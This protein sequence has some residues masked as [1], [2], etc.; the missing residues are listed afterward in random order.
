MGETD[1]VYACTLTRE[2]ADG[3]IDADRALADRV[4]GSERTQDSVRVTFAPDEDTRRLVDTFVVNESRCCGFFE[5]AVTE[6]DQAV[7]L[8]IA[9]PADRS[10]Q[11]LVDAAKEA[12]DLGPDAVEPIRTWEATDG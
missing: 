10:A 12:F 3:R 6:T 4:V 2:E 1:D 7:T 9:A 8:E 11:E 5:F